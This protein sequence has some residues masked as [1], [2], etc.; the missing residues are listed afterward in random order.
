MPVLQ[1]RRVASHL[2]CAVSKSTLAILVRGR[3][4][5]GPP[6]GPGWAKS[7]R[8]R[9]VSPGNGG[10]KVIITAVDLVEVKDW[11]VGPGKPTA[12]TGTDHFVFL[13]KV[14]TTDLEGPSGSWLVP[15]LAVPYPSA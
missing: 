14:T 11:T 12:G 1:P 4:T 7:S 2:R 3:G 10:R 13:R 9:V 5:T 6:P 8:Q 15:L